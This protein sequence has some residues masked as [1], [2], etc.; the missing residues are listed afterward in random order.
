ML[1]SFINRVARKRLLAKASWEP[2]REFLLAEAPDRQDF[3]RDAE[4]LA[5]DLETTGLDARQH[6]IVSFG[7]VLISGGRI[8]LEQARHIVVR[9]GT[10]MNQSATIHGIFDSHV[11]QGVAMESALAELLDQLRGRVLV[12]HHAPLD[13]AFLNHACTQACGQKLVVPIIDTMALEKTRL[14]RRDQPIKPGMLRL[15]AVRERY[16]LAPVRAHNALSDALATAE[17]LLAIIAHS[18]R[19]GEPL[20]LKHLLAR[21]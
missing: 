7:W 3:W 19:G 6:R 14:D 21:L 9:S 8:Q 5:V 4:L 12:L 15:G 16:G 13:Q 11:A 18:E 2:M 20:Q 1:R 17:L 10:P